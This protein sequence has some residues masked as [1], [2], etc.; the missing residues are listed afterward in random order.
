MVRVPFRTGTDPI[1]VLEEG[2]R[3]GSFRVNNEV[4]RMRCKA[5]LELQHS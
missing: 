2:V 4:S 1:V 3:S 5:N